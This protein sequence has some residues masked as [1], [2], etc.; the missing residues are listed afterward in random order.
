MVLD[1]YNGYC[2]A[3]KKTQTTDVHSMNLMKL[4]ERNQN[5][6]YNVSFH[7]IKIME[8]SMLI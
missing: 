6:E 3:I 4:S 2:S 5:Q 1:P 7:F 8:K